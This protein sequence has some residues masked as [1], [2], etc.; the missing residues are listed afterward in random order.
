M[1]GNDR[2]MRHDAFLDAGV[3]PDL[4]QRQWLFRR[5]QHCLDQPHG[6]LA[7]HARAP[8]SALR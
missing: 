2:E 1:I 5:E 7:A 3:T 8:E 4:G 6:R